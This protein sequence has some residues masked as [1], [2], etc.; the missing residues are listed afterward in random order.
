MC[1]EQLLNR[2]GA[3]GPRSDIYALG[4]IVYEMI[5]GARPF[6]ATSMLELAVKHAT[7]KPP[8][9]SETRPE[10]EG[11]QFEALVH[12]MLAKEPDDRPE[13]MQVV[14]EAMTAAIEELVARGI[15]GSAY[16]TATPPPSFSNEGAPR[17]GSRPSMPVI[18]VTPSTHSLRV[19]AMVQ[20]I[21]EEA[22]DSAV[23]TLLAS[24]PSSDA[25][26]GE[27]LT[28]ALWGMLQQ[29]VLDAPMGSARL[30]QNC[31]HLGMLIGTVIQEHSAGT[32][33][34][35]QQRLFR[36][37]RNVLSLA[38]KDRRA[39]VIEALRPW[40]THPLFPEDIIPR[41]DRRSLLEKLSAPVS[42]D[43]IRS[44]LTHRIEL[45]GGKKD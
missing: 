22:N 34:E 45:F 41:E 27:A 38:E 20:R 1:P 21:R 5:I 36:A 13:S 8:L 29:E 15:E 31:E 26:S 16:P 44:L 32:P 10:F 39:Q 43:A 35:A 24:L 40:A 3:V 25:L 19:R 28:M 6:H 30:A 14:R 17:M 4:V 42:G 23:A 33:S 12:T 37:L 9:L 11:S 7:A 18:S 2:P